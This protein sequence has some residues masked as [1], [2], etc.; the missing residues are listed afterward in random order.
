MLELTPIHTTDPD[1]HHDSRFTD[2]LP[3]HV[4]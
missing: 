1:S 3:I 2:S 4:C